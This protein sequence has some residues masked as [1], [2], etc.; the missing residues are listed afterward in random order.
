[1]ILKLRLI[2]CLL[3]SI[4]I[5]VCAQQ[6]KVRWERV[7]TGE[8]SIIEINPSSLKFEADRILRATFRTLLA[9]P[10]RLQEK[11]EVSYKSRLE[12]ITFTLAPRRYRFEE[13]DWLDASGKVV[14][15]YK[16]PSHGELRALKAGG[17]MERL[18]NAMNALTPFGS[19]KVLAYRFADGP[20]KPDDTSA[21]R[22]IGT[23]VRISSE[24]AE[25]AE[26]I[27]LLPTYQSRTYT[28]KEFARDLGVELRAIGVELNY[29]ESITINCK[30]GWQPAQSILIQLPRDEM[31][32]L[33]DGLFLVLGKREPFQIAQPGTLRL[34]TPTQ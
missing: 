7:Y 29:A 24:Q 34:R 30:S 31:L 15:S 26:K 8:D 25:V 4:P 23:R 1:M 9:K 12:T 6:E 2:T 27:C 28:S 13:I 16:A 10:E 21:T 22:L 14:Q 19:W 32:M 11:S 20:A 33:W 17:F 5:S 18:F 3:F